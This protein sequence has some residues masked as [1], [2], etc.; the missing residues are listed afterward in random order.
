MMPVSRL[1]SVDFPLPDAPSSRRRSPRET[2]NSPME[3]P[4]AS[5]V[6]HLYSTPR[7][8]TASVVASRFISSFHIARLA[9]HLEGGLPIGIDECHI[10]CLRPGEAVEEREVHR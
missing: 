2:S 8:R 6:F 5:R 3:R 4:N 1:S 10:E 9:A 7:R